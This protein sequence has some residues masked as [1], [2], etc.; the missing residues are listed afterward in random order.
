M[1]IEILIC[2]VFQPEVL[3]HYLEVSNKYSQKK[4]KSFTPTL[5]KP[6]SLYTQGL[7]DS[8][9][10]TL[11]SSQEKHIMDKSAKKSLPC[12]PSPPRSDS[13]RMTSLKVVSP[14][15]PLQSEQTDS[16]VTDFES[17]T[18]L[19]LPLPP[20]QFGSDSGIESN[21]TTNERNASSSSCRAT[22]ASNLNTESEE[23][24]KKPLRAPPKRRGRKNKAE[25]SSNQVSSSDQLL[26]SNNTANTTSTT[27][28]STN[29]K[30]CRKALW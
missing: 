26:I 11:N 13:D 19:P 17:N 29:S 23:V 14:P 10:R 4:K 5:S 9:D 20:P 18:H 25:I 30:Y 27:D 15:P 2:Y 1:Y 28:T 6:R 24:F 12:V 7:S 21:A 16:P 8:E 22:S 3:Q